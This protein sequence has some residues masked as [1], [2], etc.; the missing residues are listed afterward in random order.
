MSINDPADLLFA[1]RFGPLI[2]TALP[3]KILGIGAF[4]HEA[5]VH[6]LFFQL[7]E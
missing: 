1:K 3:E 7:P 4:F 2:F 6:F 5:F